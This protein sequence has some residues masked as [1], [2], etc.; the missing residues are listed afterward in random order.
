MTCRYDVE[1]GLGQRIHQFDG[2]GIG[3]IGA[4]GA[5]MQERHTAFGALRPESSECRVATLDR[6]WFES[7]PISCG[8]FP[9][10]ESC[11]PNADS[12][13]T[14]IEDTDFGGIIDAAIG[15]Q[16]HDARGIQRCPRG[17]NTRG[18]VVISMIVRQ[19]DNF[20]F[21]RTQIIE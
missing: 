19:A 3:P 11:A 21:E 6:C 16:R 12:S 4:F 2:V 14:N 7:A 20:A 13:P 10:C 8:A 17:G 15:S 5:S 9:N 18:T 1:S